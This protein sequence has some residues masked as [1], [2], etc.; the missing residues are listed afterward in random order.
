VIIL[1]TNVLSAL[2]SGSPDEAVTLWLNAQPSL[3]IWTTAIT[4][5]EIKLGLAAM[6]SGRRRASLERD[7]HRCFT[8]ILEARILDFD[9]AAAQEAATLEGRRRR[10]GRTHELRDTMI[11]GIA[12]AQRATLATRNTRHFGDLPVPVV[13]PWADRS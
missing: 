10:D 4:L 6:P 7:F 11:A 8:D 2:M 9:P 5:F 1:D 13:N 3:S 12:V